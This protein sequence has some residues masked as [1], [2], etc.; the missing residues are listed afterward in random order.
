MCAGGREGEE[1]GGGVIKALFV[2]MM[3]WDENVQLHTCKNK[4]MVLMKGM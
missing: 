4:K 2:E 3:K 1:G